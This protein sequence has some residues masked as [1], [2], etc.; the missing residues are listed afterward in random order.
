M[1]ENRNSTEIVRN[2]LFFAK[3]YLKVV[4]NISRVSVAVK[5]TYNPTYFHFTIA[6][7]ERS[8][9]KRKCE[10]RGGCSVI[11]YP[12]NLEHSHPLF[13]LSINNVIL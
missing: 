10:T 6:E 4:W 7:K 3:C 11:A 12:C 1:L 9:A 2:K 5:Q 13:S 8:L